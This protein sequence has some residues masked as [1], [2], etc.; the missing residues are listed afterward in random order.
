MSESKGEGTGQ[1]QQ[2]HQI[3]ILTGPYKSQEGPG[4]SS[5]KRQIQALEQSS[6]RPELEEEASEGAAAEPG[7][8][9]S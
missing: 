2:W 8:L 7:Q 9:V 3:S 5:A 6:G 4:L 1:G